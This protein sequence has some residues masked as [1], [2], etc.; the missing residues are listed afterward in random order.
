MDLHPGLGFSKLQGVD[1]K[2]INRKP[3]KHKKM[4]HDSWLGIA[5]NFVFVCCMLLSYC[6]VLYCIVL[7]CVVLYCIVL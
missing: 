2:G 3:D 7:C 6:I 4:I 1:E 5:F